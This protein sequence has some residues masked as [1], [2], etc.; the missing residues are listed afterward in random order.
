M[1]I[2]TETINKILANSTQQHIKMVRLHEQVGFISATQAMG[3]TFV[4]QCN[5]LH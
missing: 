1:D 4:N 3:L 2:D 5:L